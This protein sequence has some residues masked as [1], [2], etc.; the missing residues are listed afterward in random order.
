MA[1]LQHL[2]FVKKTVD[3]PDQIPHRAKVAN[4]AHERHPVS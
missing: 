2:L 1:I 4:Y 3:S